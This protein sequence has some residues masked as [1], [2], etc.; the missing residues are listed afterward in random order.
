MLLQSAGGLEL[1]SRRC[2][3]FRYLIKKSRAL[4]TFQFY[5]K[6]GVLAIRRRWLFSICLGRG[7]PTIPITMKYMLKDLVLTSFIP[8]TD[9]HH[10]FNP[11]GRHVHPTTVVYERILWSFGAT[12]KRT[13]S[14]R[15]RHQERLHCLDPTVCRAKYP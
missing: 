5:I 4:Q 8:A 1:K 9:K 12:P 6:H 3:S 15:I 14:T 2:E 13:Y 7:M 10:G 11:Y